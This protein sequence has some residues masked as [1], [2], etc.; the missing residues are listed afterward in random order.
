MYWTGRHNVIKMA[1]SS[2]K[3]GSF[4][5]VKKISENDHKSSQLEIKKES[6]ADGCSTVEAT[7][8]ISAV[9]FRSEISQNNSDADKEIPN[10]GV[11]GGFSDKREFLKE[12]KKL[13]KKKLSDEKKRLRE[14]EY[15]NKLLPKDQKVTIVDQKFLSFLEKSSDTSSSALCKFQD[16]SL[17]QDP[18]DFPALGKALHSKVNRGE[19]EKSHSMENTHSGDLG[20]GS[21]PAIGTNTVDKLDRNVP[22][23][24]SHWRNAVTLDLLNIA[25]SQVVLKREEDKKKQII[26]SQKDF[27]PAL[28][29]NPLDSSNPERKR[30]KFREKKRAKVSSLKKII[31]DELEKKKSERARSCQGD[32]TT[33]DWDAIFS[34]ISKEIN[35]YFKH[36]DNLQPPDDVKTTDQDSG[37]GINTS[38]S[39]VERKTETSAHGISAESSSTADGSSS[40]Y[41][42]PK[43]ML[44]S[45]KFREYCDHFVTPEINELTSELIR[46]LLRLQDRQYQRDPIKA[47]SKRKYVVGLHEAKK[48]LALKKVKLL[49]IAPDIDKIES[50][51]GLNDIISQLKE[52]AAIQNVPCVFALHRRKIGYLT[53]KKCPISCLAVLNYQACES[54]VNALLEVVMLARQQYD[55]ASQKGEPRRIQDNNMEHQPA[56]QEDTDEAV[57][58]IINSFIS[59]VRSKT[60]AESNG[61]TSPFLQAIERISKS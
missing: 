16:S 57:Q 51:G 46:E 48:Y 23:K 35:G 32:L 2:F 9:D 53:L 20:Q 59:L 22:S 61:N 56:A 8:L 58:E 7:C 26:R 33:A 45:R 3:S 29:G 13:D 4:G 38:C 19:K 52:T 21:E 54:Q 39:A 34:E 15:R 12:R 14:Q 30:G 43:P 42:K 11:R 60:P 55:D 49:I 5:A 31:L 40:I 10:S 24:R 25:K 17:H 41:V 1:N 50:A 44:H 18:N 6:E 27:K 36:E 37:L 28:C 47:L